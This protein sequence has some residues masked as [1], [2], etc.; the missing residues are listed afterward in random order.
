MK[1]KLQFLDYFFGSLVGGLLLLGQLQRVSLGSVPFYVHDV[2]IAVW[3]I[4]LFARVLANRSVTKRLTHSLESFWQS[5]SS[6]HKLFA[7]SLLILVCWGWFWSFITQ[8]SYWPIL[9]MVRT[10]TYLT[11]ASLL[12]FQF[13]SKTIAD[14]S[15]HTLAY[16]FEVYGYLLVF[17]GW[18]QWVFIPDTRW[19]AILGWDDHYYRMLGTQFDPNFWGLLLVIIWWWCAIQF[20]S[21]TQRRYLITGIA[22]ILALTVTWSRASYL[23]FLGSLLLLGGYLLVHKIR[24]SSQSVTFA[25]LSSV[26][27][28]ATIAFV[29]KPAGEGGNLARTSTIDSRLT[30]TQSNISGLSLGEKVWGRGLFNVDTPVHTSNFERA[31]HAKLPNNMLAFFISGIGFGGTTLLG[32]WVLYSLYWLTLRGTVHVYPLSAITFCAIGIHSLANTSLIQPFILLSWLW[33]AVLEI[34]RRREKISI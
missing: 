28:M 3:V 29:P 19:L 11:L 6:V 14:F 20:A 2:V 33:I 5:L 1:S 10:G 13:K 30:D 9:Y 22:A 26:L 32:A 27:L 17:F 12:A 16:G 34:Q 8:E 15:A 25:V 18:L 4:L 24:I 31:N 7:V 23:A 21:L